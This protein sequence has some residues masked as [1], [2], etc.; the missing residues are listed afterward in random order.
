MTLLASQ[1]LD[2]FLFAFHSDSG[3]QWVVEERVLIL[4]RD[5]IPL[6]HH[7][8]LLEL[9]SRLGRLDHGDALSGEEDQP[10]IKCC[11]LSAEELPGSQ[12]Q[13]GQ[14]D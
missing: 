3:D 10:K 11:F 5:V 2:Q 6:S 12:L 1:K 7:R 13:P 4:L 8:I 9:L 14:V